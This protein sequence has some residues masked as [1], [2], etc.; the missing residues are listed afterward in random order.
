MTPF[1]LQVGALDVGITP[2]V[3]AI[4][5]LKPKVLFLLGADE[6]KVSADD[7]ARKRHL[8]YL[9]ERCF[10]C[11]FHNPR[12]HY[13]HHHPVH[14]FII[15]IFLGIFSSDFRYDSIENVLLNSSS[16]F[17]FFSLCSAGAKIIYLG[18]HGE[19]GAAIADVVLPGAAYTEKTGF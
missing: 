14:V 10:A 16:N 1:P 4:K 17:S 2:G 18:S 11:N 9:P 7:L 3:N 8:A 13:H 19:A 12:H 15:L 6:G 5:E